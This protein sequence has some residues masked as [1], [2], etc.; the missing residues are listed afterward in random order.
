MKR[1][2]LTT[3]L[4]LLGGSTALSQGSKAESD[5]CTTDFAKFLV[6]QQVAESKTVAE[7]AKRVRIL[8][9]SADF[10]WKLDEPAAR[11]YF[12]DAF[13]VASDH[14]KEKGFERRTEKGGLII[15]TPDQ[16]FEVVRAIARK[17]AAWARRLTD[18]LLK[19][20]EKSAAERD[21]LDK[22]NELFFM[23]A[24]AREHITT[25]PELSWYLFRR[26]M[27]QP[28]D[29]HWFSALYYVAEKDRQ[30][31][32]NLY[33]ELLRNYSNET[34]RRFL[35]LSGY[36]FGNTR[37][38]GLE[39]LYF[40]SSVPTGFG[41]SSNLQQQF[42]EAW[43]RRVAAYTGDPASVQKPA[44]ENYL[45]EPL[46]MIA[47][48]KE[49]EPIIVERFP[50]LLQR[51]SVALAQVNAVLTDEMRNNLSDREER[52]GRLG[53]GFDK[54][55]EEVEDADEK[56][57]LT[58]G[59]IIRL[60][61]GGEAK[62]EAQ[63]RK[64]EPWLDKI[65]DEKVRAETAAYF[66]FLRAKLAV[67]EL[68]LEE[69]RRFAAKVP[70]V[71]HR[72]ILWFDI[73]EAQLKDETEAAAVY[74]TLSDVGK[75][76]RQGEDSIAKARVLLGLA[77]LYEKF[78]HT[79][80]LDELSD[81]VKGIN[82]LENPDILATAIRRQITGKGFSY[83]TA[84][85]VPGYDLESTFRVLSKNDFDIPLSNARALE[86]RY[87]STLA[88]VAVAQNCTARPKPKASGPVKK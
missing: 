46:Y 11:S 32:D 51:Y 19:E 1:L 2:I 17:D 21:W 48:L 33:L 27:R 54:L 62:T 30:F 57:K 70:E 31:A 37:T 71:D 6:D 3:L 14:F 35:F 50:L 40:S 41:P 13:K 86:D 59:M 78:N 67:K 7:A 74:S 25:D 16:R 12:S 53:Y 5:G 61:V 79:F 39:R 29:S 64:V 69:A 43:F 26:A 24:L 8:I 80:A 22:R 63:F 45:P 76:A 87:L 85:A 4:L 65:A 75:M 84:M 83:F 36:P 66:W 28:L 20:A 47:A 81:A 44:E 10:L 73:A 15:Q 56:G 60:V 34:P 68:R 72:A 77:N 18:Q 23:M 42:L 52:D 58:D 38:F 55:L 9:R 49:M 82:R 88:V